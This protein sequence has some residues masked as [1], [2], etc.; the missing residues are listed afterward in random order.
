[1]TESAQKLQ[2]VASGIMQKP[3][4]HIFAMEPISAPR[5][6]Q[7]DKWKKR[8]CVVQ[9]FAYKKAVRIES[10]INGYRL[11]N[12]LA[13]C[14]VIPMPPSWSKKKKLEMFAMPHQQK[15]DCDNLTKAFMDSFGVDDSGV[16]DIR[17]IKIWG[18]AG[19]IYTF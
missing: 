14:F 11:G 1:M 10:L 3:I 18:D 17:A 16:W 6:T 12:T 5:M 7:A 19:A 15:P 2:A 13:I 8:S 4:K 9:Y